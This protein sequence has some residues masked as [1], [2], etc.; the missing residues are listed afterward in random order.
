VWVL[1]Y[2]VRAICMNASFV[3]NHVCDRCWIMA[4]CTNIGLVVSKHDDPVLGT[5]A[6]DRQQASIANE[7]ERALTY[8]RQCKVTNTQNTKSDSSVKVPSL[9]VL[10]P[11]IQ[12]FPEASSHAKF[13]ILQHPTHLSPCYLP[14]LVL[15]AE[16]A[17]TNQA[18]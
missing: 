2:Q 11:T 10:T 1:V 14:D 17:S 15:H 8:R 12:S 7:S 18:R 13:S 9:T 3:G 4:S 5:L 16:R 6:V